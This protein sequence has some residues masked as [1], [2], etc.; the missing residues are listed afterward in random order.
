MK[1][2]I[3]YLFALLLFFAA[4]GGSANARAMQDSQPD[5]QT[6]ID[7][8]KLIVDLLEKKDYDTVEQYFYLPPNFKPEMFDVL[9]A[10]KVISR[11]GVL[12]IEKG[13][14]FGTVNLIFGEKRAATKVSDVKAP[15]EECYAMVMEQNDR[16]CEVVVHWTEGRFKIVDIERL[17]SMVSADVVVAEEI[18]VAAWPSGKE[19]S[20]KLLLDSLAVLLHHIESGHYEQAKSRVY[21]PDDFP[22]AKFKQTIERKELSADGITV[23]RQIGKYG[24]AVEVFGAERAKHFAERVNV[25]VEECFAVIGVQDEEGE[26]MAHWKDGKFKFLRADDIGKLRLLKS[27]TDPDSSGKPEGAGAKEPPK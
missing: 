11:D 14:Q 5:K 21:V 27:E 3:Y 13:G 22:A 2:K 18:E 19:P 12:A 24:T 16:N 8:L 23:M 10:R 7:S 6:L 17:G 26:T 20:K 4:V 15:V 25:P 9:L 1:S